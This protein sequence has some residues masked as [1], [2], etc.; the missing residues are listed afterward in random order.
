MSKKT[1][2]MT[3]NTPK[4]AAVPE[5]QEN[6]KHLNIVR[7]IAALLRRKPETFKITKTTPLTV[8]NGPFA[9]VGSDPGLRQ[10]PVVVHL[11]GGTISRIIVAD[12]AAIALIDKALQQFRPE[13]EEM[14]ADAIQSA[15]DAELKLD[16]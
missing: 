13:A 6:E 14:A 7:N 2:D 10:V 15:L 8:S 12:D 11:V 5:V 1:I 4:L 3:P 9:V 16:S